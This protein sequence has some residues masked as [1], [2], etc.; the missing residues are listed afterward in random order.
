MEPLGYAYGNLF[1]ATCTRTFDP[2]VQARR[3]KSRF[4]PTVDSTARPMFQN[5]QSNPYGDQ[6]HHG[7]GF[8]TGGPGVLASEIGYPSRRSRPSGRSTSPCTAARDSKDGKSNRTCRRDLSKAASRWFWQEHAAGS[9]YKRRSCT[10]NFGDLHR[11]PQR[12]HAST[13]TISSTLRSTRRLFRESH[14]GPGYY[15]GLDSFIGGDLFAGQRVEA[16]PCQI[17]GGFRYTGLIPTRDKDTVAFGIVHTDTCR[18]RS[19][20]APPVAVLGA[21]GLD[22]TRTKPPSSSTTPRRSPAG[23]WCSRLSNTTSTPCG[24]GRAVRDDGVLLGACAPKSC[25][26]LYPTSPP[27]KKLINDPANVVVEALRGIEAA[28]GDL[29]KVHYDPNYITR[30]DAPVANKVGILSGGGSGHEP[31]HG[32]FVGRGNA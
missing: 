10:N 32:G 29:L 14:Y 30:R 22:Y 15:R 27:M 28:H 17:T 3:W 6:D 1:T 4:T 19:T 13:T 23:C 20:L 18:T 26:N 31:L 21:I 9:L 7:F 12:L 5:G 16:R 2:A 25:S 8:D 11:P 24:T